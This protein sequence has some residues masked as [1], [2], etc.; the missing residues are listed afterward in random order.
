[1]TFYNNPTKLYIMENIFTVLSF[2]F[3]LVIA[4]TFIFWII[5]TF[6]YYYKCSKKYEGKE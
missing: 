3:L 6:I 4:L 5:P 1:M 2:W